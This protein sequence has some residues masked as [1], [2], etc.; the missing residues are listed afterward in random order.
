MRSDEIP[1]IMDSLSSFQKYDSI[2]KHLEHH[3]TCVCWLEFEILKAHC[4]TIWTLNIQ[5]ND[6]DKL[7]N[8]RIVKMGYCIMLCAVCCVEDSIIF[9]K[10][11][12]FK[13]MPNGSHFNAYFVSLKMVAPTLRKTEENSF[14]DVF[15]NE[16]GFRILSDFKPSKAIHFNE[17]FN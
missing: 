13:R 4:S 2:V 15:R 11:D 10:T 17:G 1:F 14:F 9:D 5:L 16:F 3:I 6:S 7:W 12:Y 8:K